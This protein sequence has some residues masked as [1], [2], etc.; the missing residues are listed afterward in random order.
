MYNTK[1]RE[2]WGRLQ[3]LNDLCLCSPKS[4]ILY[5]KYVIKLKIKQA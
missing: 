5:E 2:Q 3:D 4:D 1:E